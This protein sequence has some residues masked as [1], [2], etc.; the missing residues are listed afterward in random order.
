MKVNELGQVVFNPRNKYAVN[1]FSKV[2][3]LFTQLQNIVNT[4]NNGKGEVIV[5]DYDTWQYEIDSSIGATSLDIRPEETLTDI[6]DPLQC[7]KAKAAI[8]D[9]LNHLGVNIHLEELNYMLT[10]KYGSSD[11]EA[12]KQMLSS[13]DVVDSIGSFMFFLNNIV[14]DGKLNLNSSGNFINQ[15]GKEI[16]FDNVFSDMAFIKELGNWKYEY[17]HSRDQLS[18]LATGGNRF[19][20]MSDNDFTTDMLRSLNKRGKW[21]YDLKEDPYNYYVGDLNNFG[22]HN[23]YGSI[24]LKQLSENPNLKM[25]IDHFIGFK[26]DKKGDEGQDYF[27]ISRRE[28]YLSKVGI[29]ENDGMISLTLSDKKKYFYVT[30]IKLPGIDYT[31]IHK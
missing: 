21:F 13:T 8:I 26:T 19:Y 4:V 20:E 30:G 27:E 10:G 31:K 22:K 2:A 12:I 29:L 6:T 24:S 9:A 14:K 18:I 16:S 15:K 3:T 28:D 25:A 11:W 7:E 23:V 1:V 5:P 17:R